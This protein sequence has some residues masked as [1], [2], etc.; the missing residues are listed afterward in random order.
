MIWLNVNIFKISFEGKWKWSSIFNKSQSPGESGYIPFCSLNWPFH[1]AVGS[2]NIRRQ[3]FDCACKRKDLSL[4]IKGFINSTINALLYNPMQK[5]KVKH[6]WC[7]WWQLNAIC[8]WYILK[9]VLR[10]LLCPKILLSR[11][12]QEK[13]VEST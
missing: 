1:K 6:M 12:L 8:I 7:L 9:I 13:I 11:N 2:Q 10:H 4:G 3:L 5:C